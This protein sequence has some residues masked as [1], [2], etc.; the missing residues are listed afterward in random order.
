[1][2]V[3]K[4]DKRKSWGE[5]THQEQ[6][7]WVDH[8]IDT[9][10]PDDWH[11]EVRQDLAKELEEKG[12]EGVD[13]QFSGFWSQGDGAS[14]EAYSIDLQRIVEHYKISVDEDRYF[15]PDTSEGLLHPDVAAELLQL[16]ELG[17]NM[18]LTRLSSLALDRVDASI[19][20]TSTRYNH[21]MTCSIDWR[22]D[23]EEMEPQ[24]EGILE[25]AERIVMKIMD[26]VEKHRIEE[27]KSAYR[28]IE[29]CWEHHVEEINGD[30]SSEWNEWR[31]EH[32]TADPF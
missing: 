4:L 10:I 11:D 5:L 27:C 32:F 8:L 16:E 22:F 29:D 1:M 17:L 19:R 15:G 13:L 21:E 25:L 12:W 2:S 18:G 24:E 28:E 6:E 14:F 30:A 7:I 20:R 23:V 9:Q 26:R 3:S 31:A